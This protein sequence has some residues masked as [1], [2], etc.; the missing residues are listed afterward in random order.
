MDGAPLR[1]LELPPFPTEVSDFARRRYGDVLGSIVVGLEVECS[2]VGIVR[3]TF[4]K[5]P[6]DSTGMVRVDGFQHHPTV[7]SKD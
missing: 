6:F 4:G 2:L 7:F 1:C 3:G 5:Y